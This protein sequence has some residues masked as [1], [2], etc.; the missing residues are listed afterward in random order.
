MLRWRPNSVEWV[1]ISLSWTLHRAGYSFLLRNYVTSTV[2]RDKIWQTL[3]KL[4]W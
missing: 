4:T 3:L 2:A 1:G